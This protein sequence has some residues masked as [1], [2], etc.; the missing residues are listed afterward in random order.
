VSVVAFFVFRWS[1][2]TLLLS[3]VSAVPPFATVWFERRA[4]RRGQLGVS[5]AGR[6]TAAAGPSDPA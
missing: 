4:D 5:A 2:K 3:L 1:W 6:T